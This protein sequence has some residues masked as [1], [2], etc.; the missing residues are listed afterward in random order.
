MFCGTLIR[1]KETEKFE[2]QT[3]SHFKISQGQ[4]YRRKEKKR[5]RERRVRRET[6][7]QRQRDYGLFSAYVCP[8]RT[9]SLL[10]WHW[11]GIKTIK[12]TESF[13]KPSFD[14]EAPGVEK[15]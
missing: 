1:R 12:D 4:R 11:V 6:D 9:P 15:Q 8:L 13:P 14:Y 5:S 3:L 7:R 10:T 2:I